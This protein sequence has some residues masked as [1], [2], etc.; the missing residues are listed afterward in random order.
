ML[1]KD[2]QI[3][4]LCLAIQ[5]YLLIRPLFEVEYQLENPFLICLKGYSN[6]CYMWHTVMKRGVHVTELG[7]GC[8][9][10]K[11]WGF[12]FFW[13]CWIFCLQT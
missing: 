4:Q 3:V 7:V 12:A 10:C 1:T 6:P 2:R 13:P 11:Y 9:Y 5:K 8:L